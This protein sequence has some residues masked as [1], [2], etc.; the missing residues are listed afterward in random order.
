MVNAFPR[1][2]RPNSLTL[3]WMT[4]SH[5]HHTLLTLKPWVTGLLTS[6]IISQGSLVE[7]I[8][9]PFCPNWSIGNVLTMANL[10]LHNLLPYTLDPVQNVSPNRYMSFRPSPRVS[11]QVEANA[12]ALYLRRKRITCFSFLLYQTLTTA[13]RTLILKLR[14]ILQRLQQNWTFA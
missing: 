3:F 7:L 2:P 8:V 6:C 5:M 13:A 4:V 12:I 11:L 10:H 1:D 9:N 14:G